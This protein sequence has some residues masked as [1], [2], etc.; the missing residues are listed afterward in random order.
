MLPLLFTNKHRFLFLLTFA[1]GLSRRLI[2]FS[3]DLSI[4]LYH[5]FHLQVTMKS[6]FQKIRDE[7][8]KVLQGDGDDNSRSL[9]TAPEHPHPPPSEEHEGG[10]MQSGEGTC[11]NSYFLNRTISKH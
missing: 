3:F 10:E 2:D 5:L 11:Y 6:F 4:T 9:E 8:Q 1:A 7:S